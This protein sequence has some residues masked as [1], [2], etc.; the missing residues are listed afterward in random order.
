VLSNQNRVAAE[1]F[2]PLGEDFAEGW[3]VVYK[4]DGGFI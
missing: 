4:E 1:D 3:L 2:Q